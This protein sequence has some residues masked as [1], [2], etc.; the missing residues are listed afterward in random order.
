MRSVHL[1]RIQELSNSII[2][3]LSKKVKFALKFSTPYRQSS[4]PY[5]SNRTISRIHLVNT[6]Q[7]RIAK[8]GHGVDLATLPLLPQGPGRGAEGPQMKNGAISPADS[9][10]QVH[11][12]CPPTR[13][14][15]SSSITHRCTRDAIRELFRF[16]F[17]FFEEFV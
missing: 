6:Q 12:I 16:D 3:E 2:I 4:S 15:A 1:T 14:S 5:Q 13:Q 17:V 7:P 8:S 9:E 11:S 10:K